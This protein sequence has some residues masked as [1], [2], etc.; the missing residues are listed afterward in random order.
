MLKIDN[1]SPNDEIDFYVNDLLV[2]NKTYGDFGNLICFTNNQSDMVTYEQ[3]HYVDDNQT[4][5]AYF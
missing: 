5:T 4:I 2:L 1:W 3:I